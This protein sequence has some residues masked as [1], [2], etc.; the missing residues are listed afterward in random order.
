MNGGWLALSVAE[1]WMVNG[2]SSLDRGSWTYRS[3]LLTVILKQN[4]PI[5]ASN[6]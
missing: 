3:S 6:F 2:E 5:P 4:P 1:V